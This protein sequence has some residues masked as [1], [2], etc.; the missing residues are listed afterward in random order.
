MV[1]IKFHPDFAGSKTYKT[2]LSWCRGYFFGSFILIV[3]IFILDKRYHRSKRLFEQN[4]WLVGGSSQLVSSW[5]HPHSQ[6]IQLGDLTTCWSFGD[7]SNGET[8][9]FQAGHAIVGTLLPYHDPVPWGLN[10]QNFL[11]QR[12]FTFFLF[13]VLFGGA[14]FFFEFLWQEGGFYWTK[15]LAL[16]RWNDKSMKVTNSYEQLLTG[17]AMIIWWQLLTATNMYKQVNKSNM[18]L[19]FQV[20]IGIRSYCFSTSRSTLGGFVN[21][22]LV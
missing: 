2:Y 16:E 3:T 9:A 7:I 8:P 6:A 10:K 17:D 12:S 14:R 19:V 5:D 20:L 4:T 21:T 22:W 1:S 11:V 15:T 18:C 13:G